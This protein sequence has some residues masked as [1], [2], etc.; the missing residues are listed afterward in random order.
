MY[1]GLYANKALIRHKGVLHTLNTRV[2][3][4]DQA[5]GEGSTAKAYLL[6]CHIHQP[7][8]AGQLAERFPIMSKPNWATLL[9]R[10]G[11][12]GSGTHVAHHPCGCTPQG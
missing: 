4:I 7:M 11:P 10:L 1:V 12:L 8:V 9:G 6:R 5:G 3:N 2:V